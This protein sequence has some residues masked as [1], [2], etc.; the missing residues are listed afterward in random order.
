MA[1]TVF[2]L[3]LILIV[4]AS[5]PSSVFA[6]IKSRSNP[7]P[8][9]L[10][11]FSLTPTIGGYFFA[12]SEQRD[13]T[14]SYGLKAGYDIIGK[15]I[16]DSMG[17]EGTLN[18]F[19][20]KSK[21]D[22]SDT[23]GYLFRLDAIYPTIIEGKWMPFLAIGAG[24]IV[25]DTVSHADKSPLLNYGAGLKYFL[26]DYLAVRVD[27]RHLIVYNNV[28]TH[29]NFEVGV[30]VS[31]YFGKERK[32]KPVPPPATKQKEK[33]DAKNGK[34]TNG[35]ATKS[36]SG[37][38]T[39]ED[40]ATMAGGG[41]DEE[42]PAVKGKTP[43]GPP[44]PPLLL[45]LALS[46]LLALE[47]AAKPFFQVEAPKE[48]AGEKSVVREGIPAKVEAV[49]KPDGTATNSA[50]AIPALEEI[51]K[52]AGGKADEKKPAVKGETPTIPPSPP[53]VPNIALSPLPALESAAKPLFQ[54]KAPKE[55]VG[56]KSLVSEGSPAKVEA[57]SRPVRP[58][59]GATAAEEFEATGQSAPAKAEEPVRQ[60]V[61]K[62]VVRKLTVKFGIN[63]YYIKPK[64]HKK[65][66]AIADIMK[67][68][69]YASARIEGHTDSTGKLSFNIKLSKQRAQSVRSSLIKLGVDPGRIST[70]D[71][72]PTRPIADNATIKGRQKNRQAVTLVTLID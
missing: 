70:V 66:R 67:R 7:I 61:G 55:S 53:L 18:Y 41:A 68:S 54:A 13:A 19:T 47:S 63:S 59:K 8:V 20:T 28:N 64:F 60:A 69:A 49:S 40:I 1:K 32:K 23:T 72:G 16:A 4:S 65:L 2:A 31:Y 50:S 29:N 57:V 39:L 62:K 58:D 48:S 5:I 10:G 30:G 52:T 14:Q 33:E 26:E 22:A 56:E 9:T 21:S 38:P 37:V 46:P 12:G 45:S 27:A 15:S 71:Y 43:A 34:K 36:A 24:G 17:I 11:G 35:T 51:A 42:K 44:S 25:I 3:I 6:V